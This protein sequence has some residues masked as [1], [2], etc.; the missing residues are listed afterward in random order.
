MTGQECEALELIARHGGHEPNADSMRRIA[1]A[2]LAARVD[3]RGDEVPSAWAA[4]RAG[5][6]RE[7]TERPDERASVDAAVDSSLV[8]DPWEPQETEPKR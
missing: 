7:D 8:A 5:E 3:Q 4:I 6:R 1:R 2:A